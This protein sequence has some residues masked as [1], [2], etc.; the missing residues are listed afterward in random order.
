VLAT[1]VVLST[2]VA[3]QWNVATATHP[4][5]A[6]DRPHVL[7]TDLADVIVRVRGGALC[8][9]TPITGTRYVL[10]A[11]HCVLDRDGEVGNARIVV[12]DGVSYTALSVIVDT[13]YHDTPIPALDAALLVMDQIIPGPSASIAESFPTS[14]YVTLAGLQPLDTDGSLLRGTRHDRLPL[15]QGAKGGDVVKVEHATAACVHAAADAEFETDRVRLPCGLVPGSSGG[16]AFVAADGA[17]TLVGVISTV[18]SNIT[19]NSLVP[20]SAVQRLLAD[21]S[22]HLHPMTTSDHDLSHGS[23]DS[24]QRRLS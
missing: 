16:G 20:L 3:L 4:L 13:A 9:G 22:A 23:A 1:A 18:T 6:P 5:P 2:T 14:G 11:A 15:P 17:W 10:T 8:S 12:R 24:I 19:A 21:P 7:H